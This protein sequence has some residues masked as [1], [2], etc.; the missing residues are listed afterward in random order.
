MNV[1]LSILTAALV[2]TVVVAFYRRYKAG[3]IS[4]IRG[5]KADSFV[6][7]HLR[8]LGS[9]CTGDIF[10][11]WQDEFGLVVRYKG[12]FGT[13]KLMICDP[14]AL[15]YI[16]H[17]SAYSFEKQRATR[18]ILE[19]MDGPDLV[20]SEGDVH[21]RQRKVMLPAFGAPEARALFPVF[22]S[23]IEHASVL[24]LLWKDMINDTSDGNS[25]TMNIHEWLG[26]ATLDAIGEAA[27]GYELGAMGEDS[28][29]LG[30]MYRNFVMDISPPSRPFTDAIFQHTPS[31]VL[32]VLFDHSRSKGFDRLREHKTLAH[33][34]ARQLVETKVKELEEGKMAKDVLSLLVKANS[35]MTSKHRL[36]EEELYA[37]MSII[38]FA[39]HDTT[40]NTLAWAL[41]EL[42]KHPEIQDRVRKEIRERE[43]VIRARG[44][45]EFTLADIESLPY[46]QAFLKE[47]MR[48]HPAV[49]GL[50]RVAAKDSIVPLSQPILDTSGRIRQEL[51]IPKGTEISVPLGCYNR[52]KTVW[53]DDAHSFNPE[54]WMKS[55]S[56]E[57]RGTTLGVVGNLMNFSSGTR[58]CIG[59]RF[60]MT[61]IQCFLL[62]LIN[63]FQFSVTHR[64]LDVQKVGYGIAV[65]RLRGEVEKTQL[66]M[67]VS[68]ADRD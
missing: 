25:I 46:F 22:K 12:I 67:T 14:K 33:Q 61:E 57:K 5:P 64:T 41:W 15:Q 8:K 9:S 40:S 1:E 17:T 52:E 47:S 55:N 49:F 38:L 30:K 3:S 56:S 6:F 50:S 37:E 58:S 11:G 42:A 35:S 21:K 39:G 32:K 54:R 44:A 28:T 18:M 10:F 23:K 19:T 51:I 62:E 26:R 2:A 29:D 48:M 31:P 20:W 43:A 7:G 36:T 34:V 4:Y 13:D 27:F 45:P 68:I 16:F 53:G 66:P 63:T 24:I 60:A 65:P 59:W